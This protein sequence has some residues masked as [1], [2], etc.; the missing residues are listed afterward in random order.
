MRVG[1][2]VQR[3]GRGDLDPQPSLV[4]QARE[5]V[6]RRGVGLRERER[7]AQAEHG[8]VDDRDQARGV[9]ELTGGVLQ[10]R[11]ADQVKDDVHRG[12]ELGADRAT[13]VVQDLGRA[14]PAHE[15][16]VVRSAGADHLSAQG[17]RE[18][19]RQ[20]ADPAGGRVDEHPLPR[21]HR[22]VPDQRLIGHHAGQ[23]E[24]GRLDE[25]QR[26]GPASHRGRHGELGAGPEVQRRGHHI[27]P[28]RVPGQQVGVDLGAHV[29]DRPGHVDAGHDREVVAEGVAGQAGPDLPVD[30]VDAGRTHPDQEVP[31]VAR[32]LLEVADL[33]DLGSPERVVHRSAHVPPLTSPYDEAR[34]GGSRRRGRTRPPER[35]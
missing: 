24:G 16:H 22:G 18:L 28:D 5:H 32:G 8:R 14:E 3:V 30:R 35:C 9:L 4:H 20:V 10:G 23:R 27:G 19:D 33:Q 12:A 26:R 15:V 31:R 7:A 11:A 25:A 13:G 2:P 6:E 17:P 1:D 21:L 34:R 29:L